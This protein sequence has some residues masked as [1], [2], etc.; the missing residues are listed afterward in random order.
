VGGQV[1]VVRIEPYTDNRVRL[2]P[3]PRPSDQERWRLYLDSWRAGGARQ[4]TMLRV[5]VAPIFRVADVVGAL[6]RAG[7]RLQV[8][9]DVA[10]MVDRGRR[11]ALDLANDVLR[12]VQAMPLRNPDTGEPQVLQ[13]Y[14]AAGA[15]WL[16][17][18]KRAILAD[19]MGLGKTITAVVAVVPGLP[20]LVL[21]PKVAMGTWRYHFAWRGDYFTNFMAGLDG[22]AWPAHGFVHVG[23][24][25]IMPA[26][27]LLALK[28]EEQEQLGPR[29][30]ARLERAR[31]LAE[32][33]PDGLVVI[34]DE[35]HKL[36]NPESQRTIRA[37]K[38]RD[39]ALEH[40]GCSWVVTGTPLY[41]HPPDLYSMI[42]LAKVEEETFKTAEA[43]CEAFGGKPGDKE[44]SRDAIKSE[45]PAILRRVMLRR[46]K[47]EVLA[48]LPDKRWE[49]VSVPI[50][51]DARK[52]A[53]EA[54]QMLEAV[55][56]QILDPEGEHARNC[57]CLVCRV[58]LAQQTK[59]GAIPFELLSKARAALATAKV[60]FL[61]E[62]VETLEEQQTIAMS[63][64][65][66]PVV[67]DPFLVWSCHRTPIDALTD[68][69]D[70]WAA[71]TGDVTDPQKREDLERDFQAGR[72]RGMALTVQAGGVAI[73]LT[74]A[75]HS[76]HVDLPWTPADQE[77][78]EDR[79]HRIGQKNACRY[80]YLVADH[81]LDR[82]LVAL[83][84]HK[85]GIEKAS[86]GAA[87]VA[88]PAQ[89]VGPPPVPA[90]AA[91]AVSPGA[92]RIA[93]DPEERHVVAWLQT[94]THGLA[95]ALNRQLQREGVLSEGQWSAARVQ[96]EKVPAR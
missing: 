89:D 80:T 22:F 72:Y 37:R 60:E 45:V 31:R 42:E 11:E 38:I 54:V 5:M 34:Y 77:Q 3:D 6:E 70:G 66:E 10:R 35:A 24:Y 15:A 83:L 7:F 27:D 48:D 36:K 90:S 71:L 13:A 64:N 67:M 92:K 47:D 94:S 76:I 20:V 41:N 44:W 18:R 79:I 1:T 73:T 55:G 32:T 56:V 8:H 25:D 2:V 30:K 33:A 21:C 9:P 59:L 17:T 86:V 52:I 63:E 62:Y 4:D 14:Q 75:C 29:Q 43:F 69:R 26:F 12:R 84:G 81:R 74:R 46:E 87:S 57:S 85:K 61:R 51:E 53:D 82:W 88:A 68:S 95:R 78:A 91:V 40:G 49:H 50:P 16:T 28:P 58:D 23:N 96:A 65:D 39:L 19:S 93:R